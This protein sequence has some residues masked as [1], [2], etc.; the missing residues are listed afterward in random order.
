MT[1]ITGNRPLTEQEMQNNATL[2]WAYF[3]EK[4]WTLNA[5]AGM[6][7]NMQAESTINPGR[8]QGGIVEPSQ[9]YGLVQWTPSTNVTNWLTANGY[10][11]DSGDGQCA[12]IQNELETGQQWIPTDTYPMTFRE[13]TQST[14]TPYNLAMVF[15]RNYER[16]AEP[17]QPIRGIYAIYWYDFLGGTPPP[18]PTKKSIIPIMICKA[19]NHS[20]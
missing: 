7:G 17:D 6:L 13:F 10:A 19:L 2:L 18:K 4:G 12:K 9:G 1:W 3:K 5:V 20:L 15:I 8:W 16:P 14:D 11:I